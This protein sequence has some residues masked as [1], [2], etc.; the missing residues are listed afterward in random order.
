MDSEDDPL[1]H[2]LI[3]KVEDFS[4]GSDKCAYLV[5][6]SGPMMGQMHPLSAG[7]FVVGRA[8]DNQIPISDPGISRKHGQ[9]DFAG[10]KTFVRDLGSTN[11]TFVNGMRVKEKELRD[12]DKIQLST[13]TIFKYAYQDKAENIFHEELYKMAVVDALTGAFN[14]RYFEDRMK[15][16]FNYS[17]RSHIPISLV[18]FDIDH[19]KRINDTEGHPAGDAVLT[20]ICNICRTIIRSE[21]TLARYGGEEFV[22]LL[23]GSDLQ[24]AALVAERIRKAVEDH[25]FAFEDKALRATISVGIAS[26][27][28]QNFSDWEKMLKLADA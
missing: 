22:I 8:T 21:D 15:Q 3:T 13:T 17:L 9:L 12:G 27:V 1:E 20:Q 14:K 7:T 28:E 2:T 26:L 10:G 23:K 18:M 5:F 6:L 16:E 25:T 24:G 19:F 11:G 4:A